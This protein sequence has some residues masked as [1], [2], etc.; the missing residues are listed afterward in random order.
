MTADDKKSFVEEIPA[1]VVPSSPKQGNLPPPDDRNQSPSAS[2]IGQISSS[3]TSTSTVSLPSSAP[4]ASSANPGVGPNHSERSAV[5]LALFGPSVG[6]CVGDFSTSYNRVNG[7]LYASTRAI[8]YFSNLFGFERRLCLQLSEVT[9]VEAYRS[10]SI[11][12]SMV[13]CDDYVF[14]KFNDR[15]YVVAIL[16]ELLRASEDPKRTFR[17]PTL[18][19]HAPPSRDGINNSISSS[20]PIEKVDS[21]PRPHLSSDSKTV[22]APL[23]QAALRPRSQSV[24]LLHLTEQESGD[25]ASPQEQQSQIRRFLSFSSSSRDLS[26][27]PPDESD[28]DELSIL[29]DPATTTISTAT[30]RMSSPVD[31]V[32]LKEAWEQAKQPMEE[33][34][35]HVSNWKMCIRVFISQLAHIE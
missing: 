18:A 4:S 14:K 34:M 21:P 16:Q 3:K 8:L 33:M 28:D 20:M 10:T 2:A 1:S 13:D 31:D 7:R 27:K 5:V 15:D 29:P 32:A 30:T 24:P 11:R 23:S 9:R 6:P 12:I 19:K 22:E 35:V 17:L 26:G 25:V